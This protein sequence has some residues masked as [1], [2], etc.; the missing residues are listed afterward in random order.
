MKSVNIGL[1]AHIDLSCIVYVMWK[2]RAV[3]STDTWQNSPS[4]DE[5]TWV[6]PRSWTTWKLNKIL[7]HPDIVFC[8]A[9]IIYSQEGLKETYREPVEYISCVFVFFNYEFLFYNPKG[10][11]QSLRDVIQVSAV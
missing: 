4:Q 1:I 11:F 3:L 6:D 9:I 2:A 7:N 5:A 10:S 8:A